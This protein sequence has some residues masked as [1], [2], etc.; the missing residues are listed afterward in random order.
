[1]LTG[2][3]LEAAIAEAKKGMTEREIPRGAA[4]VHK[5]RIIG[6]GTI[7]IFSATA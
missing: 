5:G 2:L 7:G 6:W 4:L 1:M 3:F